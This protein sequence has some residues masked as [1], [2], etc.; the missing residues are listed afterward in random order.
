MHRHLLRVLGSFDSASMK[1]ETVVEQS[2]GFR[3]NFRDSPETV[4]IYAY[5]L[6]SYPKTMAETSSKCRI[7]G[8]VRFT[9]ST[10]VN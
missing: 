10:K 8:L 6:R 4:G 1:R 5:R 2:V 7:P 9:A 3:L